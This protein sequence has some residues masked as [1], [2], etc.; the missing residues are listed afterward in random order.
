MSNIFEQD[1]LN[2]VCKLLAKIEGYKFQFAGTNDTLFNHMEL[3]RTSLVNAIQ[4]LRLEI[5][6]K[7]DA[8]EVLDFALKDLSNI[9]N[10]DFINKLNL[11]FTNDIN[12]KFVINTDS[13]GNKQLGL[14]W[15]SSIQIPTPNDY[16]PNKSD[17]DYA[18][19]KDISDSGGG[20]TDCVAVGNCPQVTAKQ[21]STD[22]NLI[23]LDKTIVGGINEVLQDIANV[24]AAKQNKI[25]ANDVHFVDEV[26]KLF[27]STEFNN[28]FN[29]KQPLIRDT[30]DIVKDD[31]DNTKL[32]FDSKYRD[33]LYYQKDIIRINRNDDTV[34]NIQVLSDLKDEEGKFV[35][36]GELV[37]VVQVSKSNGQI[38]IFNVYGGIDNYKPILQ[39]YP[40]NNSSIIFLGSTNPTLLTIDRNADKV[41]YGRNDSPNYELAV[42]G[43][44]SPPN[45]QFSMS[46][47]IV[48]NIPLKCGN[49]TISA[50]FDVSSNSYMVKIT[51]TELPNLFIQSWNQW[52]HQSSGAELKAKMD[53]GVYL[54][55]YNWDIVDQTNENDYLEI[56]YSYSGQGMHTLD[57]KA[58][59]N[60]PE[61]IY[62]QKLVID[63]TGA[64]II[65]DYLNIRTKTMNVGNVISIFKRTW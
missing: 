44:L 1:F 37:P 31:N 51:P 22:N 49:G 40:Q 36:K 21:N 48:G 4:I 30:G 24:N 6:Q 18:Q 43:D 52:A 15:D 53:K 11:T 47:P 55:R 62:Q 63:E 12:V 60:G 32:L 45:T 50:G 61:G 20:P 10:D 9:T 39:T 2:E 41:F 13:S 56:Q 8:S 17:N 58:V 14:K 7:L 34:T 42:K 27:H 19:I 33:I 38:T 64:K 29:N 28:E 57:S 3:L 54:V 35:S 16:Y 46:A 25:V 59:A 23:T 65:N 26:N 5:D